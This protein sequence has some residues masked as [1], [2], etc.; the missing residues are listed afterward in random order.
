MRPTKSQNY[1]DI[2]VGTTFHYWTTTSAPYRK[3]KQTVVDVLC[4]CGNTSTTRISRLKE[5]TSTSCG[6]KLRPK[7]KFK[8]SLEEVANNEIYRATVNSAKDR[9]YDFKLSKDEVKSIVLQ[10]CHYCGSPPSNLKKIKV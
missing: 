5:K 6:C 9:N 3:D 4:R 7:R 1:M 10:N 8:L 2:V